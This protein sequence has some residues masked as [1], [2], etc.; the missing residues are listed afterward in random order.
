VRHSWDIEDFTEPWQ[1]LDI[2]YDR[3]KK[4]VAEEMEPISNFHR[5]KVIDVQ[6]SGNSTYCLGP[7]Y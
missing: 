6:P 5:Y 7:E 3:S 4:F 1:T 2:C